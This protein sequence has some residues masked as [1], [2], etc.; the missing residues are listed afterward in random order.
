MCYNV[1]TI[2]P[3][4][5]EKNMS[6]NVRDYNNKDKL[7]F[8]ASIGDYLLKDHLAWFIYDVVEQLDLNRLYKKVPSVGNPSYHPK[9]M[10]K[11]LFYGYA[12]GMA[13]VTFCCS[14]CNGSIM[15]CPAPFSLKHISHF[16]VVCAALH[17]KAKVKMA[18]LADKLGSVQPVGEH[19]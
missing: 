12:V 8:P 5:E 19:Y 13:P 18:Y 6:L 17:F 1:S 2:R 4:K 9:M 15:A 14:K 11:V 3:I 16:Y 7:L 10:L